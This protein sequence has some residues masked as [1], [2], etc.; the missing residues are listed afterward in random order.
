MNLE[1]GKRI[2][3]TTLHRQYLPQFVPH[4]VAS[5][6]LDER[7]MLIADIQVPHAGL[8]IGQGT[9]R[10]SRTLPHRMGIGGSTAGR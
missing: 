1:P 5:V 3:W 6:M 7:P 10:C 8:R 4:S 9:E 2:A